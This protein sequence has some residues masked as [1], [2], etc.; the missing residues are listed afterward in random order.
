MKRLAD[1]AGLPEVLIDVLP[2]T[3]ATLSV[4]FP[5]T[6]ARR[7]H[8]EGPVPCQVSCADLHALNDSYM[9]RGLL[10]VKSTVVQEEQLNPMGM[11]MKMMSSRDASLADDDAFIQ[12]TG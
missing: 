7:Y 8:A 4:Q 5:K 11:M 10:I 6:H 9:C 3:A 2:S 12:M 1:N